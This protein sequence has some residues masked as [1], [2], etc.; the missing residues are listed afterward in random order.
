MKAIR[1]HNYGG[2]EVLRLD[3]IPRPVP[4][5]GEL[6]IKVHA[7]TVNPVDWTVRQGYMQQFLPLKLPFV[8]GWDLSGVVETIGAGVG[9]F[10]VGDEVIA[11]LPLAPNRDGSYAEYTIVTEGETAAKPRTLDHVQASTIGV[12][13]LTA[14]RALFETA[15]L[16]AGQK[17]LIHRAAGG[18]GTFAVQFAHWKGAYVLGTAST[19][20][21]EFLRQLGVDQPIDYKKNRFEDVASDVD[22]VLDTFGG[23]V[24]ERSWKT[25]RKGGILVSLV[26]PPA[27]DQATR[28]GVRAVFH[29]NSP[30]ATALAEIAKLIDSGQCKVFVDT[31]LPLAEARRAQEMS[32]A[33]HIRGK[34][35]LKVA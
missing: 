7:A 14:W 31:V 26:G 3:D 6:L 10:K 8:P 34:I 11:S 33:G 23:E 28:H 2:P 21:Q 15:Q 30:S 35:V 25:L 16:A 32:A 13:G 12:A 4:G 29:A 17:V 1:F 27:A 5:P 9:K 22:V 24:Q 19:E 20:N 18:V